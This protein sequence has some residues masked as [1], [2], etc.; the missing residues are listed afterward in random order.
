RSLNHL[1]LPSMM[2]QRELLIS[3]LKSCTKLVYL[4][5]NL[6]DDESLKGLGKFIPKT[7]ERIKFKLLNRMDFKKSLRCFLEEYMNNIDGDNN[8]G[9]LKYL[10]FELIINEYEYDDLVVTEQF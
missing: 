10:E 9:T 6:D 7:L 1:E 8:N 5:V 2:F 3:I 4:K